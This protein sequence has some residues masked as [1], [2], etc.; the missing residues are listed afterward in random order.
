VEDPEVDK[1][2]ASYVLY[3]SSMYPLSH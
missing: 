1:A 3:G 2:Y